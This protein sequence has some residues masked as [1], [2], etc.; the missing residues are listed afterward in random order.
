VV[1]SEMPNSWHS[2]ALKA[3]AICARTYVIREMINKTNQ[4]YD[5]DASTASQVYGGIE[6][7]NPTKFQSS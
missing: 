1:P 3:Q 6:K 7:E 4:S 2:E 5:V